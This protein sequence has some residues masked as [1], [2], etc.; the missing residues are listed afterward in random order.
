MRGGK[1]K[2]SPCSNQA[3]HLQLAP[4]LNLTGPVM[5]VDM[6]KSAAQGFQEEVIMQITR[7]VSL[8]SECIHWTVKCGI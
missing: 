8:V 2:S 5:L 4:R 1:F 3:A 7:C 6:R